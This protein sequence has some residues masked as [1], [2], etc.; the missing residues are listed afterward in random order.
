M[1]ASTLQWLANYQPPAGQWAAAAAKCNPNNVPFIASPP[2][3]QAHT[4][5]SSANL[6]A[7]L[8]FPPAWLEAGALPHLDYLALSGNAN[9]TGSLPAILPWTQLQTT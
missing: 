6:L 2:P 7:G 8:A 3:L 1:R 4:L 9:L 5:D